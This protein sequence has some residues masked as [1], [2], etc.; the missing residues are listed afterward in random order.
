MVEKSVGSRRNVNR[1]TRVIL[2]GQSWGGK[3]VLQ[4]ARDL[5]KL[6]IEQI[7]ENLQRF[8]LLRPYSMLQGGDASWNGSHTKLEID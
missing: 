3:A 4:K 5:R 7:L 2:Y 1:R 6:G 8:Y